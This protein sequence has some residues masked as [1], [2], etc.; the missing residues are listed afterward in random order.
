MGRQGIKMIREQTYQ[1]TNDV[2]STRLIHL[3][4]KAL[5]ALKL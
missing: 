3:H 4:T 1:N 5:Y 2:L